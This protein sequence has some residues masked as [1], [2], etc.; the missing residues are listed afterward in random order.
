MNERAKRKNVTFA[1]VTFIGTDLGEYGIKVPVRAVVRI[2]GSGRVKVKRTRNH[3]DTCEDT[4]LG[5][6]DTY[7]LMMAVEAEPDPTI[8]RL[9]VVKGELHYAS[10]R[11]EH[12]VITAI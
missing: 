4:H 5:D 7:T 11:N 3:D 2:L 6:V 8:R 10:H 12:Y 9:D 1:G